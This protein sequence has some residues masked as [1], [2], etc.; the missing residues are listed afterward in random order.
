MTQQENVQASPG[1]TSAQQAMSDLWDEH[2]RAEFVLHD[3]DKTMAT[4]VADPHNTAVSTMTGGIGAEGVRDFYTKWFI[5]QLAPDTET[6]FVSRTV[7]RNQ[8]VDE[9]IFKCTHTVRMDWILPGVAPTGKRVE[10]PIVVVVGFREGKIAF[11]RI[12]WD[13]ASVLAQIGL[14][15][16]ETLPVAGIESARKVLDPD[17]PSNTLIERAYGRH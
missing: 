5:P 1:L 13:Q 14:I 8:L 11:E 17:L 10:V 3:V 4:M 16:A 2:L 15:D 7:G 9:L 6:T 12:Y